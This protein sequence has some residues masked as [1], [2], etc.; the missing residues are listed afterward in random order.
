MGSGA[1]FDIKYTQNRDTSNGHISFRV[2]DTITGGS[3]AATA[4]VHAVNN[5]EVVKYTGKILF[6]ENRKKI[7]RA[8]DQSE[9]IHIV[10]EF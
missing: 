4:Y 8:A 6:I 1:R 3:S 10:I 2:G 5:P 9:N 7:A